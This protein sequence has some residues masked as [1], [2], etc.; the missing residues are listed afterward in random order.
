MKRRALVRGEAEEETGPEA[1][2]GARQS[3]R[4]LKVLVAED[5]EVTQ[6]LI[7]P[8]LAR[9]GHRAELVAD[10]E[11]VLRA[12]DRSTYDVVLMDVQMPKLDGLEATRRI[13][14]ARGDDRPYIIAMTAHALP[15]ERQHCFDAGM[16]DHFA[17]PFNLA[18]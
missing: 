13:R 4:G 11:A 10:G 12:I 8:M 2:G 5:N 7:V 14:A 15:A 17:K 3:R 6:K 1:D 18:T 16:N 9:L